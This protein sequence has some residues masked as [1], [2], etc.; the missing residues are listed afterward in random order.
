VLPPH[1]AHC[2]LNIGADLMR[3]RLRPPRPVSQRPRPQGGHR[4]GRRR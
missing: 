2:R 1:L 4:A 3:A